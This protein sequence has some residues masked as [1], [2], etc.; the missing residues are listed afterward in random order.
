MEN[1]SIQVTVIRRSFIF[2]LSIGMDGKSS[3]GFVMHMLMAIPWPTA[4]LSPLKLP[5][6]FLDFQIAIHDKRPMLNH[7][8]IN[9]FTLQI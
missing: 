9:G 4:K 5:N 2:D 1:N 6:S 8:L 3:L 7:F